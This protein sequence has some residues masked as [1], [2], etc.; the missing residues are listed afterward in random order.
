MDN[1]ALMRPTPSN[2]LACLISAVS[3][4]IS[5][6]YTFYLGGFSFLISLACTVGLFACV[7]FEWQKFQRARSS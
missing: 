6:Y 1:G 5:S 7:A 4:S 2:A 3:S